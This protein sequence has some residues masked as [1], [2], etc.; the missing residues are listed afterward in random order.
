MQ[1]FL[2]PK[3]MLTPG[4]AGALLMFLANGIAMQF[5]EIQPRIT[6]FFLSFLI[7]GIL[8]V[9]SK[10]LEESGI[11]EKLLYWVLN[12]FVIFV[13]GFGSAN[14]AYEV[15]SSGK[16][17]NMVVQ[18][19]GLVSSAYAQDETASPPGPAGPERFS[20]APE[21]GTV[22][23]NTT[24]AAEARR[25]RII[26]EENRRL[27]EELER[28]RQEKEKAVPPAKQGFFKKW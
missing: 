9:S 24:T 17:G 18:V 25:L 22:H 26:E 14:V 28:M 12:S 8:I 27:K 13:V 1:E 15:Q 4:G 21:S 20:P 3:S 19:S 5:P 10:A 7:S 11:L 23:T 6:A 2:N 16:G